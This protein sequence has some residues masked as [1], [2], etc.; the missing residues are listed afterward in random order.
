MV[1][2]LALCAVDRVFETRSDQTK[3][4]NIDVCCFSD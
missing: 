3:D 4:Y 1:G 2:V